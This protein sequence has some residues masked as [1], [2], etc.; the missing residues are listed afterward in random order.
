MSPLPIL[1]KL[2]DDEFAFFKAIVY[3]EAGIKLS[4]MK[5][6]LLQSRIMRRMRAL[7]ISTFRD[8]RNYLNDFYQ[9]EIVDFIN[10]V[11]TNKTEFLRENKHFDF[12]LSTALPNFEKSNREEIRIWSA[13]CSTGEEPYSIAVTCCEYFNKSK[14]PVKILA[15]DID[16]QVL[17]Q[18]YTGIYPKNTIDVF[19]PTIQQRYFNAINTEKGVQYQVVPEVKKMITFKRLNLLDNTY[20]MRKKFD[21][22]FCRNVIIYFDKDTQRV[23]FEKMYNY[24]ADDGFL[25]IGHSENLSGVNSN[26]KSVG[27]TIYRK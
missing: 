11:T 26:F 1:D 23:L 14:I 7:Q 3:R 18:G 20:P 9:D 6:A 25:F 19:T 16:T 27:H 17:I 2:T 8:Y 13:G 12:M 21:I 5:V 22:I 10:A 24:I 4:D 15:T